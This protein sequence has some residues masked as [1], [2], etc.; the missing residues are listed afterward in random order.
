VG[1]DKAE[2]YLLTM[3]RKEIQDFLK[4]GLCEVTFT[5]FP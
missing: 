1:T 3:T 2:G 4:K 5:C